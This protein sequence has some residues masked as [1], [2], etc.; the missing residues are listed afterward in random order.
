MVREVSEVILHRI[1]HVEFHGS[2]GIFE[3]AP[4]V[5]RADGAAVGDPYMPEADVL[6]TTE[7]N[8]MAGQ[9][10]MRMLGH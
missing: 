6:R 9:A 5:F 1:F 4:F 7:F 10:P 8:A 2:D 3:F